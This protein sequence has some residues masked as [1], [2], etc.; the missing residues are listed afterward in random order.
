M[1]LTGPTVAIVGGVRVLVAM[2]DV[3]VIIVIVIV[4]VVIVIVI[5]VIL[6]PCLAHEPFG[7][8]SSLSHQAQ[9]N[10]DVVITSGSNGSGRYCCCCCCCHTTLTTTMTRTV[11]MMTTMPATMNMLIVSI[12]I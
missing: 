8:Q 10:V 1:L 9:N 5:A 2:F 11:K 4:I 6:Q 3:I 12:T 7:Q